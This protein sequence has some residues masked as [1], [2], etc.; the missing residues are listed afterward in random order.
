[1]PEMLAKG[2][3]WF[4]VRRKNSDG[5]KCLE[6]T[7]EGGSRIRLTHE[8]GQGVP[9]GKLALTQS[10]IEKAD[11]EHWGPITHILYQ[12]VDAITA[13]LTKAQTEWEPK[14]QKAKQRSRILRWVSS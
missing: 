1:M 5:E 13:L 7:L 8:D 3:E 11:V 10:V 9:G 2:K 6:V 14:T 4:V 12:D